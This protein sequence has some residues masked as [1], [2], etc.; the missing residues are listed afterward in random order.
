M[1]S[2]GGDFAG[3]PVPAHRSL[4]TLG[5]RRCGGA[6]ELLWIERDRSRPCVEHEL[7][8]DHG[9]EPGEHLDRR[10]H[11]RVLDP[12]DRLLSRPSPVRQRALAQ[13]MPRTELSH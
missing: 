4:Q 6:R 7:L 8:P 11:A 1:G 9:R 5:H 10:G 12:A 13:T 2:R 3:E